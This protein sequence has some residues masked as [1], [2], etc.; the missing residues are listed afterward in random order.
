MS[1]RVLLPLVLMLLLSGCSATSLMVGVR[2]PD[3]G[4]IQIGGTRHQVEQVLGRRLWRAGSADSLIYDVYQYKTRR[5]AKPLWG[6]MALGFDVYSLG[7]TEFLFKDAGQFAPVK[8]VSVA[9]NE[10]NRVRFVSHTWLV[11][12]D[13]VGPCRRMRALFPADSAVPPTARPT[14][15]D[16]PPG[17]ASDVAIL[18]RNRAFHTRIDGHKLERRLVELPPGRH[19]VDFHASVYGSILVG[20]MHRSYDVSTEVEL[21]PGRRYRLK[22]GRFY[23]WGGDRIDVFWIEDVGSGETLQASGCK[24]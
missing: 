5:P 20:P 8:Q 15:T 9:Y 4:R 3:F 19:A 24:R 10:Q 13:I 14:P 22:S 1:G 18:E 2:E 6:V 7:L 17:T 16:R 23:V 11:P 12:E 21:L